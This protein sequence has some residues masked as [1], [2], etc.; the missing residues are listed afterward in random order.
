MALDRL[1]GTWAYT[2]QHVAVPE[3]VAGQQR[4]ERVLDG[5]FVMLHWT[6]EHPEFP[7]AIALLAE[8]TC[9]YFDVRGV[10]RAFDFQID[11]AG[12][13]MIRRDADFW[14]R[15]AATFTGPDAIEGTGENSFDSGATWEHDFSIT[16]ARLKVPTPS[17][18]PDRSAAR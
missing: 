7:N 10:T 1:L 5:A 6:N 18:D 8:D 12:W 9:H 16:Y 2:M 13:S 3:A 14:Q 15:S 17:S 11:D 4:Y